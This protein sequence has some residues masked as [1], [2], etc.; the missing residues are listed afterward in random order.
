MQDG[1]IILTYLIADVK[2]D[3]ANGGCYGSAELELKPSNFRVIKDSPTNIFIPGPQ[4]S[5]VYSDK[6]YNFTMTLAIE[7]EWWRMAAVWHQGF[8]EPV[9][10]SWMGSI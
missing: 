8:L 4:K 6:I 1:K 2:P 9:W 10:K 3:E 5:F 7:S